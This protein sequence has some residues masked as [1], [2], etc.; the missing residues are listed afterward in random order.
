MKVIRALLVVVLAASLVI[1]AGCC[2]QA[3]AKRVDSVAGFR[4]AM[5]EKGW[6]S[7]DSDPANFVAKSDYDVP[8]GFVVLL[9]YRDEDGARKN[10]D[11]RRQENA[12][13]PGFKETSSG[14]VRSWS[15]LDPNT[16][17]KGVQTGFFE[18]QFGKCVFESAGDRPQIDSLV[19]DL[20]YLDP[21]RKHTDP[22]AEFQA[23]VKES[24]I[25]TSSDKGFAERSASKKG[26]LVAECK[27]LHTPED[28]KADCDTVVAWLAREKAQFKETTE[29]PVRKLWFVV[30]WP[31]ASGKK[32]MQYASRAYV[33]STMVAVSGPVGSRSEMDKV[34]AGLGY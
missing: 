8:N 29:G 32:V 13:A 18:V 31:D 7:T 34:M 24:R 25:T 4:S 10:F 14:P 6:T 30:E 3:G 21:N 16:S 17:N 2:Q 5:Q 27:R 9:E 33:G 1:L 19:G 11:K 22:I 23:A 15:A 12:A 26:D 20:G 28:A